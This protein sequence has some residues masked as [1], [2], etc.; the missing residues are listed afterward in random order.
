MTKLTKIILALV[1][2]LGIPAMSMAT[3]FN[4]NPCGSN[5]YY[6]C[7][8]AEIT[9]V[10]GFNQASIEQSGGSWASNLAVIDQ[11]GIGNKGS[12]V[13]GNFADHNIAVINQD[14]WNNQA[15]INQQG[16]SADYNAAFVTQEGLGNKASVDQYSSHNLASIGQNG[17]CNTASISQGTMGGSN[18]TGTISQTGFANAA[19]ILQK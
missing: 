18:Y 8:V 15:S 10:G 11:N 12:I 6:G 16:F 9:Q 3:C 2:I 4:C 17:M 13:Q 5:G 14:G 7:T 1:L 19:S